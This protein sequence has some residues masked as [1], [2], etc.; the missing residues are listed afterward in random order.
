MVDTLTGEE[1]HEGEAMME[2]E[3][4]KDEELSGRLYK[5]KNTV[6][7]A[8]FQKVRM[9]INNGDLEKAEEFI[10][11]MEPMAAKQDIIFNKMKGE[12]DALEEG[13]PKG[14]WD[15][16]MKAK[17]EI[18]E[19]YETLKKKIQS[20]GK[21]AKAAGA[22]AGAVAA[23]K[24]KGGGKGPTAKQLKEYEDDNFSG[25]KLIADTPTPT[26]ISMFK[27]FFPT[28]VKSMRDAKASLLA[29][30]KSGI[31]DRMGRYAPMFV[32]VQY[33]D[34][35]DQNGEKYRAHQTQYY[36]SNFDK[37]DPN[38]NPRVTK[39]SLTKL[40]NTP[41]EKTNLGSILV[42]TSDYIKDLD[43]LNI[44]KRAM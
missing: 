32:H 24:A 25:E 43:Q 12:L 26:D 29:H 20:Q 8:F 27:K 35:E 3:I 37:Q 34:F 19:S 9:M 31:K 4:G 6:Q 10:K 2:G 30:D 17:D 33:H 11:R 14:F 42:K 36:N 44:T 16:K 5:I 15:K 28:G 38:F 18:N 7:P 21:S 39:L 1:P 22:I 40:G 41:E 23:Y 13:L